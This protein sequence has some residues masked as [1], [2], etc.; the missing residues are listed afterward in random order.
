[1]KQ[2]PQKPD[3]LAGYFVH[4]KVRKLPLGEVLFSENSV[5]FV[6][7]SRFESPIKEKT[8]HVLKYLKFLSEMKNRIHK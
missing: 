8:I 2:E 5:P 7:L 4:E 1:M 6:D 3:A